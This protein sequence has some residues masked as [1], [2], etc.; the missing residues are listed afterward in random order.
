MPFYVFAFIGFNLGILILVHL[1]V[2]ITQQTLFIFSFG[3]CF[4][5]W[6]LKR[7]PKKLKQ[8]MS[9]L[10]GV[11][12]GGVFLSYSVGLYQ[13]RVLPTELEK[14]PLTIRA[15]INS[16]PKVGSHNVKFI[17]QKHCSDFS[18]DK[19][20]DAE[21]KVDLELCQRLPNK[22][23]VSSNLL[24]MKEWVPGR[25]G[26]FTVSLLRPHGFKN[27][28][29]FDYEAWLI[30]NRVGATGWV[31]EV[32]WLDQTQF[33]IHRIRY[34]L[35]QWLL[36]YWTDESKQTQQTLGNYQSAVLNQWPDGL[37]VLLALTMGDRSLI[38]SDLWQVFVN[39][40]TA[41]LMA[42][43]GLHVGLVFVVGQLVAQ[44][45]LRFLLRLAWLHRWL[46]APIL[47][48]SAFAL[49]CALAY[50]ALA[51]FSLPTQRALFMLSAWILPLFLRR[52]WSAWWRWLL[53]LTLVLCFDPLASIGMG[54]WLSFVAV[55]SLLLLANLRSA[56]QGIRKYIFPQLALTG[57][58]LPWS[59]EYLGAL[60]WVSPLVNLVA[61]PVVGLVM[62]PLMFVLLFIALGSHW[63][64]YEY[65]A[66][67][68][69]NIA[70][71]L[72]DGLVTALEWV[73]A[74]PWPMHLSSALF[75]GGVI[76]ATLLW[77]FPLSKWLR[78][79]GGMILLS[80]ALAD[81]ALEEHP[82][83]SDELRVTVFDV[84][85]GLAVLLQTGN[86]ALLYDTGGQLGEFNVAEGVIAPSLYGL[87]VAQIDLLVV[88]HSDLDHAG[89]TRYL[90][91]QFPIAQQMDSFCDDEDSEVLPL[92]AATKTY[93]S[94]QAGQQWRWG[95][96]QF[97]VL[98]PFRSQSKANGN[99]DSCVLKVSAFGRSLLLTG[100]IE[101]EAERTLLKQ[102]EDKL[103]S[104][105]LL[106]PHHGSK[107]S[108]TIGFINHVS[109]EMVVISAG[110]QNRFGHPHDKVVDRYRH[111]D[112]AVFNTA[113][114]GALQF[115][116]RKNRQIEVLKWRDLTKKEWS[117]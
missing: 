74:E 40:G 46:S 15:E 63:L 3:S 25:V 76:L 16:L 11:A 14:K 98:S 33:N 42:I 66:S 31:N 79:L 86:K 77:L 34:E 13:Q 108:S 44:F 24:P 53:A 102:S 20:L 2:S 4:A 85:Q 52:Q 49:L 10:F 38:G 88:S 105:I 57:L 109:P 113:E 64:N 35:R 82:F 6:L 32:Q 96:V 65:G 69:L 114:S 104:T 45:F 68:L 19:S 116:V 117:L 99:D 90:Q 17:L 7:K 58:S 75:W 62:I 30:Q 115:F 106:A 103:A 87:G 55:A 81:V 29:G 48:S 67:A 97:E 5:L 94:C 23:L 83:S 107:T 27:P 89:G 26:M 93:F 12:V 37:G 61:I 112:I 80:P 51:G 72:F 41:H 9:F 59:V 92:C 22:I 39:T 84:G 8:C 21:V 43:S 18:G 95:E 73:D 91:S 78:L 101:A 70:V 60:V 47:I 1:P 56:E 100:D 50:A 71:Y 54:F 36:S 111:R 28:G 110:Y